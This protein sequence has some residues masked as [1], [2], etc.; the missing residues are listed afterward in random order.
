M[1][2]VFARILFL[3]FLSHQACAMTATNAAEIA[4]ILRTDN[5]I[6]AKFALSGTITSV[7]R[8]E[9]DKA[10]ITIH[11]GTGNALLVARTK[12]ITQNIQLGW[13]ARV[14]GRIEAL[15]FKYPRAHISEIS[16]VG[17]GTLPK[18]RPAKVQDIRLGRH[19]FECVRISGRVKDVII[20][21]TNSN[22]VFLVLQCDGE[23]I[24]VSIPINESPAEAFEQL[25]GAQIR[26]D[27]IPNAQ[28]G[29]Y[30]FL[31]GRILHCAGLSCIHVI[32][33]SPTDP[34]VSPSLSDLK[35][36]SP[37]QIAAS[38]RHAVD[39]EVL[40]LWH[41]RHM[42][43]R[44]HTGEF[45]VVTMAK[46][47]APA[48][49]SFVR[50][51]GFPESD[52]LHLNLSRAIWRELPDRPR[53]Q[54]P[55]RR[56]RAIELT[57]GRNAI[58][59]GNPAFHGQLICIR[60]IVRS[61]SDKG[62][63]R[64]RI[65]LDADGYII[66]VDFG[67]MTTLK[68]DLVAGTCIEVTGTCILDVET[69]RPGQAF[70]RINGCFI[71]LK[72]N[73]GLRIISKPSWWT[74]VRAWAVMGALLT[75]LIA[76]FLWNRSLSILAFRR[77]REISRRQLQAVRSRLKVHERTRLAVE[78]HD[79][80]SQNLTGISMELKT[81]ASGTE[82]LSARNNKHLNNA[83]HILGSCRNE[84]QNVLWDLRHD[85]LDKCTI[86][87]AIRT[88]LS[89]HLTTMGL[90]VRF[91]VQ[92]TLLSD[93]LMHTILNVIREL[94]ANAIRHGHATHIWVAATKLAGSIRFSVRDNG[95]GFDT[96]NIPGI[97]K[98]HFGLCGIRERIDAIEG[99][100]SFDSTPGNGTKVTVEIPLSEDN[101]I[102]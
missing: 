10:F 35:M 13:I 55:P 27:G 68:A 23:D 59:L 75:L 80:I 21:E 87:E 66:P 70:P 97:E 9:G 77:G 93:N 98:G 82:P 101:A 96:A 18:P 62:S 90:S 46:T 28:D 95:I 63:Q 86:N 5:P 40:A 26:V 24:Y 14:R 19:D 76:I 34:F 54:T 74:P 2:R 88:T 67:C 73:T 94:S 37:A 84:L 16:Y 79:A 25:I 30:R 36:L 42:L 102:K 81:I 12:A 45:S 99:T 51:I 85:A 83:M 91:N 11:D 15:R 64:E 61:S 78:L 71:V 43:L 52:L 47:N 44:S 53:Q 48:C 50:A 32:K 1:L 4:R 29:S 92:R 22:W 72:D 58:L 7:I 41:P 6:D 49:G 20:S 33:N 8:H 39:G 89:P 100:V 17:P 38:D 57:R 60:G 31:I 3:I 56:I 65:L 69:W